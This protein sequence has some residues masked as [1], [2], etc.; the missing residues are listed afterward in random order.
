MQSLETAL[1]SL[2]GASVMPFGKTP[3]APHRWE[4][5]QHAEEQLL[6]LLSVRAWGIVHGPN[7]VGKSQ[8]VAAVADALPDKQY[9]VARLTHSTLGASDLLRALCHAL[10]VQ[11]S[12]R[13]S[14]TV[15]ALSRHWQQ[16]DRIHPVLLVDEAQNLSSC[17]MEELRLLSCIGL[18]TRP[19]FSL[20]LIGDQQLLPRLQMGVQHALRHRLGFQIQLHPMTPA[21]SRLYV[22]ARLAEVGIRTVPFEE[23]AMELLIQAAG[24]IARSLNH[25]AQRSMEMAMN[26]STQRIPATDVQAAIEQLPW[27]VPEST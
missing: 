26:R 7:G 24:G 8:L 16:L 22:E 21:Q 13:R 3:S 10:E 11:P 2:W 5:F 20:V 27:L 18:D 15:A 19:I 17:A 12:F 6:R 4:A 23:K 9:R 14:D 25:L 1:K